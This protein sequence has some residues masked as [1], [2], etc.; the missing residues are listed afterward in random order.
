MSYPADR[1]VAWLV[2]EITVNQFIASFAAPCAISQTA[3]SGGD[4]CRG[5]QVRL[6][7]GLKLAGRQ[8]A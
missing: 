5:S 3:Q 6:K 4:C 1:N 8:L 7:T 2:Q